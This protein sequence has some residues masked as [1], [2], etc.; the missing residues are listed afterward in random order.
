MDYLHQNSVFDKLD[1]LSYS[2]SLLFV[3][4]NS[5]E[6]CVLR[7]VLSQLVPGVTY[8][9]VL[10]YG[11]VLVADIKDSIISHSHSGTNTNTDTS[12]HDLV[13]NSITLLLYKVTLS[14]LQALK[15]IA[16]PGADLR[17]FSDCRLTLSRLCRQY[18]ELFFTYKNRHLE[19]CKIIA[20]QASKI[21]D[22]AVKSGG[23]SHGDY[24][25][26]KVELAKQMNFLAKVETVPT[27]SRITND[28]E[29]ITSTALIR[30]FPDINCDRLVIVELKHDRPF[31]EEV[32]RRVKIDK[33]VYVLP[34]CFPSLFWRKFWVK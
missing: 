25:K 13:S 18:C 4:E 32:S 6:A 12:H 16:L 9:S 27:T 19:D 33:I 8:Q 1:T 22:L 24:V 30:K 23:I 31:L 2:E 15:A 20:N 7:S 26:Q 28:I 10:L 21:M 5:R 11:I 17:W 14:I 3:R 29:A 34:P